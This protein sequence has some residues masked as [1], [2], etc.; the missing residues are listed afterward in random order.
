MLLTYIAVALDRVEPVDPRIVRGLAGPGASILGAVARLAAAMAAMTQPVALVLD[1]LELLENQ[2]CLDLVGELAAQ[3]PAGAQPW[4]PPGLGHH[5]QAAW[6]SG[7]P[8][9]QG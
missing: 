5:V 3:L 7:T 2:A 1:H 9:D 4:W 8:G 6:L